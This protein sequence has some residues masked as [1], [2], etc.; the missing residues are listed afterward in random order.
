MYSA[1]D[2]AFAS[3]WWR[4]MMVSLKTSDIEDR[5]LRL[6]LFCNHRY[7]PARLLP[8]TEDIGNIDAIC[9]INLD[10]ETGKFSKGY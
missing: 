8:E 9:H 3:A 4:W 2:A 10:V 7:R 6:Q 1:M 5:S